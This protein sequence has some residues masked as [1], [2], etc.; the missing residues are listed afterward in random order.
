MF[1]LKVFCISVTLL[2]FSVKEPLGESLS[3]FY[4]LLGFSFAM[5]SILF[6]WVVWLFY[7]VYVRPSVA[8]RF[9]G[10]ELHVGFG[11]HPSLGVSEQAL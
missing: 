10:T 8:G 9:L 1:C 7:F 4:L 3:F 6:A 5:L 11:M 2:K